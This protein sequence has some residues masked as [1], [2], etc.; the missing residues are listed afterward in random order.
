MQTIANPLPEDPAKA[1]TARAF[2]SGKDA[3]KQ[4]RI[5]L[6]Q[7]ACPPQLIACYVDLEDSIIIDY[8]TGKAQKE[9]RVCGLG[10]HRRRRVRV[11]PYGCLEE[12]PEYAARS[13]ATLGL[14]T[15]SQRR[16]IRAN[17][18]LHLISIRV[19]IDRQFRTLDFLLLD[20]LA[21]WV[22][23]LQ[24]ARVHIYSQ[25]R[26]QGLEILP[27]FDY[28][29]N[30]EVNAEVNRSWKQY[31][32]RP[33]LLKEIAHLDRPVL[34]LYGDHDIR[35]SWPVEQVAQ[36]LPNAIF[37]MIAGADHHIWVTHAEELQAPLRKFVQEIA[38]AESQ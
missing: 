9:S 7:T 35:P 32:Q 36:L 15:A 31:I 6:R 24:T 3:R 21:L 13:C 37:Q 30:L 38:Q 33:S 5:C 2:A 26:D 14:D 16:R 18:S 20:D 10:R 8:F 1:L 28:P 23:T 11:C 17:E 29:P 4:F 27:P 34:F 22:L 25:R 12:S 19:H